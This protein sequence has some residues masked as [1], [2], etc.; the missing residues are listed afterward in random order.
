MREFQLFPEDY[1]WWTFEDYESLLTVTERLKPINVL[2]FGPGGSTLAMLEGGAVMVDSCEDD[3]EYLAIFRKR[4][5]AQ[6][7]DRV[8]IHR[9]TQAEVLSIP[10]I[11]RRR[12]DM[13]FIDGPKST[14]KRR[15][16]IR[17]AQERCDVVFCHD[18]E[19]LTKLFGFKFE[20]TGT[21]G[22]LC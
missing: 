19:N 5:Q 10:A 21:V 14:E 3:Q 20:M 6:H 4:I 22:R 15:A 2:E 1:S 16:A 17:F 18:A 7:A 11:N 12:F 9:F 13:A 8:M